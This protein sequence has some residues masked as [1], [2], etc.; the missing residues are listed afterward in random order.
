VKMKQKTETINKLPKNLKLIAAIGNG[1]D[2]ACIMSAVSMLRGLKFSDSPPCVCPVIRNF[3]IKV[4]DKSWWKSD[5]ERTKVLLPVMK[6]LLDTKSTK[7]V[8]KKR[9]RLLVLFAAREFAPAWLELTKKPE[10][11]VHAKKLR[12]IKDNS[13]F[14]LIRELCLEA[15]KAAAAAAD[16]AAAAAY[17]AAAAAYAAA[18]AAAAAAYAAAAADAY[19][20]DAYA[21][22]AYAAADA[23]A[24]AAAYAAADAYADA[25][26]AYAAADAAALRLRLRG[27]CVKILIELSKVK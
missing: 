5:D 26:A 2:T 19:A 11:I 8:E 16:A 3:A 15:K 6:Y 4:N 7:I 27:K 22:V 14:Q 20:A 13:N 10:L 24:Y 23:A 9:I 21:A 1:K 12:A 25:A 17:A 18:D